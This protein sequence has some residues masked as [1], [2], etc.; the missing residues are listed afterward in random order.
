MTR[1]MRSLLLR[2]LTLLLF[3]LSAAAAHEDVEAPLA[4]GGLPWA[5]LAAAEAIEWRDDSAGR[6]HLKPGFTPELVALDGEDVTVSGFML[7]LDGETRRLL[8]F[9]YQPDCMFHMAAG[10]TGFVDVRLAADLPPTR[11]PIALRGRLQLVKADRGGV[12]FR[13]ENAVPAALPP[14]EAAP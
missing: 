9:R 6:N 13:L 12:F 7:P 4:D 10:P 5:T 11:R 14:M 1:I 2:V 8:L 3:P